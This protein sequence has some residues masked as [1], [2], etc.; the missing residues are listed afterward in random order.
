M[1]LRCSESPGG[2]GRKPRTGRN[3]ARRSLGAGRCSG[4]AAMHRR[5]RAMENAP[6]GHEVQGEG[7][8]LLEEDP[9]ARRRR[10]A[11]SGP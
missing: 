9:G 6:V 5:Q 10:I 8:A 11:Q 3:A 1:A 2:G 4:T 7:V